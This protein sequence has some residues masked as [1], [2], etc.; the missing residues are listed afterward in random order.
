MTDSSREMFA[1]H[2]LVRGSLHA[3]C[4]DGW[5]PLIDDCLTKLEAFG[6]PIVV[7]RIREKMG[8]LRL[9][10]AI[11]RGLS[12]KDK[13]RWEDIVRAAEG[14]ALKTCEVCGE[15]G[16]RRASETGTYATR[17]DKHEVT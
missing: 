11:P 13:I 7:R 3:S 17:C 1:R 14:A 6:V 15:P 16:R 8:C 4:D 10:I 5:L 9:D 2:V 12:A